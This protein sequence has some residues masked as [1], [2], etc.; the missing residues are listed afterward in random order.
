VIEKYADDILDEVWIDV[1]YRVHHLEIPEY[2]QLQVMEL[3][4]KKLL[5]PWISTCKKK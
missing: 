2:Y 4:A 5:E 1:V 3:V